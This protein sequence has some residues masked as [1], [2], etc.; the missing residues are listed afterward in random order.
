ML[1]PTAAAAKPVKERMM[2][3]PSVT[4]RSAIVR[5]SGMYSREA[6]LTASV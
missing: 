6:P 1:G 5:V 3:R 4:V 2:G